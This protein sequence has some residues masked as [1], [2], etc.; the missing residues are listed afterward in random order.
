MRAFNYPKSFPDKEEEFFLQM[1]LSSNKDFPDRWRQW[2]EQTVFDRLD[3][4]TAKLIP[5][6]YLRLK[7]SNIADDEIKKIKGVY[8]FTW[9]KNLLVIDAV[10][11]VVSLFGEETIPVVLLKGVPLLKNVYQNTGARSIA[12]V[13]MV[14]DKKHVEKAIAL[15]K[16]NDW[17]YL[18]LSPFVRNRMV[19][20]MANNYIKEIT[21]INKQDVIIDLH[22]RLFMY[23]FKHNREH[24]M[25]Y[26]EVYT[27]ALD[28]EINGT[29]CKIPCHEDMLIHIIV[30]GAEQNFQRTLRWVLD[31]V[32]LIRTTTI[33]WEFLLE[34]IKK[35]DVPVELNVAFSYLANQHSIPA[36]EFFLKELRKLP[37]T[38]G[39]M[40]QYYRMANNTEFMVC[41]KL[42][43]LWRGYWCFAKKG[44]FFT[45]WYYFIDYVCRSLGIA[46]KRDLPA[47]L[48]EKYK[49]R[50]Q[51]LLHN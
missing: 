18:E 12:D 35:F 29:R 32:C 20:P 30:H 39:R 36:P 10:K 46:R 3:K 48:I 6:L 38:K 42:T 26:E 9:Y 16:A 8:Q 2:K 11:K 33:D 28:F 13:D 14:I 1:L 45:S 40:K 27:H 51:R 25:S 31:A 22:W 47:F 34:R 41:G 19:K 5:F 15:L 43:H 24:P 4:A 44:N 37:M 50:I 7:E 17:E 21:F 23:S 49:E